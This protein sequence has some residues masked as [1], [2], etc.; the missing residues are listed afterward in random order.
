MDIDG[1]NS[2]EDEKPLNEDQYHENGKKMTDEEKR[3]NFLERNR[4]VTRQKMQERYVDI[5]TGWPL[6]NVGSGK[7]NGWLIFKPRSRYSAAKTIPC[8]LRSHRCEKKLC[9]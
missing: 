3:K 1:M 4:Y 8:Q 2:D 7:S 6:L 5:Y 9:N